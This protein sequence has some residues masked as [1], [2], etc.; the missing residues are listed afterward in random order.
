MQS[1]IWRSALFFIF[2]VLPIP[3]FGIDCTLRFCNDQRTREIEIECETLFSKVS[4]SLYLFVCSLYLDQ[5]PWTFLLPIFFC[6][7]YPPTYL[8]S[9]LPLWQFY[10]NVSLSLSLS[11]YR[12]YPA[13]IFFYFPVCLSWFLL[14]FLFLSLSSLCVLL[15]MWP[16]KIAKY[17]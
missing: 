3:G 4:F 2:V 5:F 9:F 11:L 1:L 10:C 16:E 7:I 14:A 12:H 17:L 8:G 6:S 15:S 13:P